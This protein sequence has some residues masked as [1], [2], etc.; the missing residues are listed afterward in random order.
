MYSVLTNF[1]HPAF[2]KSSNHQDTHWNAACQQYRL[3]PKPHPFIRLCLEQTFLHRNNSIH[4]KVYT[5]FSFGNEW[6]PY[7]IIHTDNIQHKKNHFFIVCFL[8]S[9]WEGCWFCS[10]F[11]KMFLCLMK[12]EVEER[13][14]LGSPAV[15]EVP[16]KG[17][18]KRKTQR[19]S[20]QKQTHGVQSCNTNLPA[21]VQII[22]N[23]H[24]SFS[25]YLIS[26]V[27]YV[28]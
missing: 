10:V 8:R 1:S 16:Q 20:N 25:K 15:Q 6:D 11:K 19:L 28:F 17:M 22:G 23:H 4:I 24:H 27:S 9:E 18:Q 13:H 5:K 12:N 3:L 7:H 14:C 21:Y 2:L 26:A